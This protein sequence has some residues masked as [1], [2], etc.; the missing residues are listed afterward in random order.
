MNST[1]LHQLLRDSREVVTE[2]A[3]FISKE[4]KKFDPSSWK[5][6]RITA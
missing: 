6:R 3:N 2:V 4:A 1:E 5:K